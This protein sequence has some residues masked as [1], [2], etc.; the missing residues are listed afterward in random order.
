MCA[1]AGLSVV[2]LKRVREGKLWL[3]RTLK[4]GQYR[5]LTHDELTML[6]S[7]S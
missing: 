4:P 3:D 2:R 7:E 1:Q 5:K 6:Q